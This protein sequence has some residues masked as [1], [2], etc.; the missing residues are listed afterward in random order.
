MCT[1]HCSTNQIVWPTVG[2]RDIASVTL[3]SVIGFNLL[4]CLLCSVTI[5]VMDVAPAIL[6]N[7]SCYATNILYGVGPCQANIKTRSRIAQCSLKVHI[8]LKILFLS[9]TLGSDY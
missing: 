8:F 1:S 9:P 2:L 4:H 7:L 5:T 6:V 3:L